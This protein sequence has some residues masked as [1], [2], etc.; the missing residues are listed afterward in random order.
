[1]DNG[2]GGDIYAYE[3][4]EL[5]TDFSAN[6][7]P[8]EMPPELSEAV[9]SGIGTLGRY[10]DCSCKALRE[11]IAEC[12]GCAPRDVICGN[13]AAELI[14][15]LVYAHRPKTALLTAPCFAEYE[16]A[17]AA[18]DAKIQYHMLS[19]EHDFSLTQDFEE[20]LS[21]DLDM[22]FLCVPNNPTGSVIEKKRL[23][24]IAD[25]CE[26]NNIILVLDECFNDFLEQPKAYSML[27]SITGRKS[28]VIL[29]SFTKMYALA[30]LRLG[31]AVSCNHALLEKMYRHRQP[32][33]V[34]TLAQRAGIAALAQT[35]FA[36]RSRMY[37]QAEKKFLEKGLAAL[38][39]HV[40]AGNANFLFFYSAANW[41]ERLLEKGFLI[42]D[43]GNY[44]GLE[45]GYYRIAVRM[46]EDNVRLL[47]AMRLVL[48]EEER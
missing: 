27:D 9:R 47:E 26:K 14:F 40:F 46:H 32:W 38:G 13:G 22:V 44:R 18:S 33:A 35:E 6:I 29:K 19:P 15:S 37:L 7:N 41:K 25:I 11:K 28:L 36:V 42:R 2:H 10:P 16:A 34:S 4:G 8:L 17:L 45:K 43:C 31:Y 5:I 3:N 30:G 12:T 20:R 48:E 1:M 39:C 24:A 21:P 23:L